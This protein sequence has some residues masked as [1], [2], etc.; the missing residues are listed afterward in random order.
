MEVIVGA[1]NKKD[2]HTTNKKLS[3]FN[4]IDIN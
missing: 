4:S 3:E 1:K 2:L